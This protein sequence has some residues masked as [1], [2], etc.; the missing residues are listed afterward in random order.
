MANE[1]LDICKN[2]QDMLKK[3]PTADDIRKIVKEQLDVHE[4]SCPARQSHSELKDRIGNSEIKIS[5]VVSDLAG[6]KGRLLGP[7]V[8][9]RRLSPKV[10][11]AIGTIL[12]AA[13]PIAMLIF[14]ALK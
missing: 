14:S 3:Q 13:V 8:F 7:A 10:L 1:V 9:S 6:L 12:G 5:N 4:N 11:V 2:I